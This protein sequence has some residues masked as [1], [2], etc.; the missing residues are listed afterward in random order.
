MKRLPLREILRSSLRVR[1]AAWLTVLFF[2]AI[3]MYGFLIFGTM[4]LF[5]HT[6]IKDALRAQA[7]VI[8]ASLNIESGIIK[9][10]ESLIESSES[11]AHLAP[12][13]ARLLDIQGLVLLE[14]GPAS[15]AMPPVSTPPAQ[16]EFRSAEPDLVVYTTAI[17]DNDKPLAILQVA[18]STASLEKTLG[19]LLFIMI[20]TLAIFL[21]ACAAGGYFLAVRLLRPIDVMTRTARR[22]STEALS[23]R[24]ALPH[25]DDELGRLA[26]TFDEM[27]DRIEISFN[28]YKQ[29]TADASHE[30]RTPVSVMRAIL[31]VTNR[32]TRTVE[33][34]RLAIADLDKAVD[35]MDTLVADLLQLSHADLATITLNDAVD[36]GGLLSN[37]V[38]TLRP[39]AAS[40]GLILQCV[41]HDPLV[42]HGD[43]DSLVHALVN[44]VDNAIKYTEKGSVHVSSRKDGT[45]ASITIQDT[46]IGIAAANIPRIF[47]RFMRLEAARST[48]GTGLGLAI[49]KAIIERHHGSIHVKSEPGIG[50]TITITLPLQ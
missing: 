8:V 46:G 24:I 39:L 30:L 31:S 49:S 36:I 28:R 47:D 32:R 23:A 17:L 21:P 4:N 9:L 15:N 40:K 22:F 1:F 48:P 10:P 50:T 37:L 27:L 33:E 41:N 2:L 5:L 44:V 12:F 6:S 29:F 18:Q 35:R 19:Q 26:A 25:T 43:A 13:T 7:D 14:S 20:A 38:E 34:Y 45:A 11:S 42:I 16:P 3:G